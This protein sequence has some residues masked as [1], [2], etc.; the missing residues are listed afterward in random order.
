MSRRRRWEGHWRGEA[1]RAEHVG[2][3]CLLV[4]G[5]E[6]KGNKNS[7]INYFVALDGSRTELQT[8][9]PTKNTRPR[10]RVYM[11]EEVRPMGSAGGARFD[12]LGTIKLGG[13]IKN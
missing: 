1:A 7:K 2:G 4:L 11:G 9:Q 3:C 6:L 10:R 13:G 5:V 8:Q 12:R